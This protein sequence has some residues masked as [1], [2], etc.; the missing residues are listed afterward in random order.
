MSGSNAVIRGNLEEN[1]GKINSFVVDGV[2]LVAERLR[3]VM[4]NFSSVTQTFNYLTG[5]LSDRLILIRG[6]AKSRG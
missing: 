3:I 2:F 6:T 5:V 1:E 4:L